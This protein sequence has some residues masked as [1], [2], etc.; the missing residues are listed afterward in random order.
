MLYPRRAA[1]FC[2]LFLAL[3]SS[4]V[5]SGPTGPDDLDVQ[6]PAAAIIDGSTTGI[7]GFYFLPPLVQEPEVTG[8]FDP[9]LEPA[10]RVCELVGSACRP[11]TPVAY[12]PPGSA[13]VERDQYQIRWDTNGRGTRRLDERKFYRLE[14]LVGGV[15]MGSIDLDPRDSHGRGKSHSP[16]GF[17]AFTIGRTI[18]VKFWLSQPA[19]C[20]ADGQVVLE[21][22]AQTVTDSQ[23]G[24]LTLDT[25]GDP[26]SLIIPPN[27]LP[28]GNPVVTV[29]VE[30]LDPSELDVECIPLLDA[31]QYGPCFRVTTIPELTGELELDAI[32]SICLDPHE[33][34]VI[35]GEFHQENQL[36]I[37][38]FATD[39]SNE[40]EA[41]PGTTG[42]CPV[43]I[44]DLLD[45]PERGFARYAALGAN[46]L[47]RAVGP[48]PVL[49]RTNIRLGGLT[50]SFSRFRFAL[51]G[52][53][54]VDEGSGAV[55]HQGE[56][57]TVHAFVR[58]VDQQGLGVEGARVHFSTA[59]GSVDAAEA[60]TGVEGYAGTHW[61]I[62]TSTPGHKS[63]TT[64]ALGLL[65][66]PVPDHSNGFP[67]TVQTLTH[68]ALVLA[69]GEGDGDGD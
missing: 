51:P 2:A 36:Q 18:P 42:D 68:V 57:R 46:W 4:C 12:F 10:M 56:P 59:D 11:G 34:P 8:A 32:V 3:L 29:V 61:S 23:G 39:G 58:V 13:K 5:D 64:S 15:V 20:E 52:Q 7:P 41:L 16:A 31:P 44:G 26:L 17:F 69:P 50:S 55:V 25:E 63:L 9:T 40:T 45:V 30:R 27:A 6:G 54:L 33:V 21:C 48:E 24:R 60:I 53:M 35:K 38:R 22:T 47:A 37:V 14:I 19:Q 65:T 49:A 62:D 66:E 1:P 43:V 28:E 67:L